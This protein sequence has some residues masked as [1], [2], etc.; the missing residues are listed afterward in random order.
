[1]RRSIL[2]LPLAMA[3]GAIPV[4]VAAQACVGIP[5]ARAHN[6]VT[7][8]I[9]FPDGG[10]SFGAELRHNFD[11]P[12]TAGVS[13]GLTSYDNVDP[14]QHG[15]AAEVNYE[16]PGLSFSACPMVGLGYTR[17]SE[18][19]VTLST[20]SVPVGVGFGT[21]VELSPGVALIPH[22]VPQWVWT[23]ASLDFLGESMSDSDSAIGALFGATVSMSRFYFGGRVLWVNEE[24]VDPIFSIMAGMP[25]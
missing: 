20:V 1:M 6:A 25:F 17:M 2:A 21:S 16:L 4:G 11:G 14:V 15:L 5:V 3:I 22:V 18:D 8:G 19:D 7:A 13:Y 9:G 12:I 23:R 10:T 24:N